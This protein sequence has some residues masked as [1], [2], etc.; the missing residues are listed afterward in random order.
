MEQVKGWHGIRAE[1]A[2]DGI[3]QE[4]N[5]YAEAGA[6]VN[7]NSLSGYLDVNSIACVCLCAVSV[8]TDTRQSD[9]LSG[10]FSVTCLIHL[11]VER[12]KM[13]QAV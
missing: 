13:L 5:T 12:Y 1:A 9:S 3:I 2:A 8:E 7:T 10:K 4:D 11:L 6:I